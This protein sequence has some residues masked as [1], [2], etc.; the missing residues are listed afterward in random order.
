MLR[1]SQDSNC[2]GLGLG[3]DQNEIHH[4]Q[5]VLQLTEWFLLKVLRTLDVS[6]CWYIQILMNLS[7]PFQIQCRDCRQ[8]SISSFHIVGLKCLN[9]NSYN[10][11]RC[12]NEELPEDAEV[13]LDDLRMQMVLDMIHQIVQARQRERMPALMQRIRERQAAREAAREAARQAAG[14]EGGGEGEGRG[15]GEEGDAVVP[16][17]ESDS[18]SG[19]EDHSDSEENGGSGS[20]GS[21]GEDENTGERDPPELETDSGSYESPPHTPPVLESEDGSYSGNQGG[22]DDEESGSDAGMNSCPPFWAIHSP[23]SDGSPDSNSDVSWETDE[24][25]EDDEEEND[26]NSENIEKDLEDGSTGP[27]HSTVAATSYASQASKGN[28][29]PVRRSDRVSDDSQEWETAS[30]EMSID[31]DT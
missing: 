30:E 11:V 14:G 21:E 4:I 15:G 5:M 1:G 13:A 2:Y 18:H 3:S 12:G 17:I 8:E 31:R 9:C 7:S 16:Q 25:E 29:P 27:T 23:N 19:S 10:T 24:E 26:E 28:I 22:S 20:D 6:C